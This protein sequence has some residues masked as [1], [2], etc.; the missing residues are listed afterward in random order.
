MNY[1]MIYHSTAANRKP[2]PIVV[3]SIFVILLA[4]LFL[5]AGVNGQYIPEPMKPLRLVNDFTGLLS[6]QQMFDLNNKLLNFNNETSTQIYVV[7]FDSIQGYDI[8]DYAQRLAQQWGIGQKDKNNGI[9]VLVSPGNHKMT[10]QSGY[11]LEGAVPDAICKRIIEKAMTPAFKA[12]NYYAGLDS[13]TNILMSLTRGEYTADQY[14]KKSGK[15][16]ALPALIVMIVLFI[17]FFSG[18]NNRRNKVYSSGRSIPWWLLMGGMASTRNS[19]W[20]GFS[21]GE[22]SFG[23][24]GGGSG[25]GFGGFGGGGGG[26]FGGGG[27][28]GG[29]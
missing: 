28:S 7:S 5:S 8:A 12:G 29:W 25:G 24:F 4:T 6:E 9:L 14:M 20:G 13:A 17:I 11:G 19:G 1:P 10:I 2:F 16:S 3:R 18:F 26:S 22:G 27:A 15:G 23:G 21:S